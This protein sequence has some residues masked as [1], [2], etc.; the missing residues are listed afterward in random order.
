MKL[1]N[2]AL[3]LTQNEVKSI[4]L[5]YKE[6]GKCILINSHTNT[7]TVIPT[8]L[9]TW[10]FPKKKCLYNYNRR[11]K[12][13]S[14]KSYH[15]CPYCP[16]LRPFFLLKVAGQYPEENCLIIKWLIIRK[17]RKTTWQKRSRASATL[18]GASVQGSDTSSILIMLHKPGAI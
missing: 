18:W 9:Q 7:H 14:G 17:I 12:T 6:T 5:Y 13:T 16:V 2:L 1:A 15:H 3:P 10:V 11:K 8:Y 4:L